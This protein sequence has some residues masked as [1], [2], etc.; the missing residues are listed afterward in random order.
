M[1][2]GIQ[3]LD[4]VITQDEKDAC[5]CC[6]LTRC[7][8]TDSDCR[9]RKIRQEIKERGDKRVYQYKRPPVNIVL[10]APETH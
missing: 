2:T 8:P 1:K 5:L 10:D 9:L 4:T 6:E 7:S 3:V